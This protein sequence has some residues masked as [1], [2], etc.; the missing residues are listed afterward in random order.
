MYTRTANEGYKVHR[1]CQERMRLEDDL[2]GEGLFITGDSLSYI[3]DISSRLFRD[4]GLI[5]IQQISLRMQ[6]DL[7]CRQ[8]SRKG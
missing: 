7:K 8:I 1:L 5:W 4:V 6:N 2:K 3:W